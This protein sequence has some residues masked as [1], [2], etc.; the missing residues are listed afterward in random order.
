MKGRTMWTSPVALAAVTAQEPAASRDGRRPGRPPTATSTSRADET[1]RTRRH[2][3]ASGSPAARWRSSSRADLVRRGAH[4]DRAQRRLPART[5]RSREHPLL[6]AGGPL[7]QAGHPLSIR[8]DEHRSAGRR[9]ASY[10]LT[11]SRRGNRSLPTSKDVAALAGV[12][13]ST[14]SYVMSGKRSISPE[15][16]KRVED[17]IARLTYE[18]NAGARALRERRSNVIALVVRMSEEVDGADTVPYVDAVV[19]EAGKR[20]IEVVLVTGKAEPDRLTRL[21]KRSICDGMVLMDI[22]QHDDRIPVAASLGVPVVLIGTPRDSHGLQWVDFDHRRAAELLVTELAETGHRHAVFINE[23]FISEAPGVESEYHFHNEFRAGL[24]GAADT[25]GIDLELV[26]PRRPGWT[27]IS[28]VAE[29]LFRRSGDRLGLIARTPK[30]VG[31]AFQIA[32]VHR[33][34]PGRDFSLVGLCTDN[35]A[36]SYSVPVTNVSPQPR[37]T[38]RVA[39]SVLFDKLDGV[40]PDGE[41]RHLVGPRGLTRRASTTVFS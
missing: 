16:R 11:M 33:L 17:A 21:A 18:P 35:V 40:V 12:S 7:H 15:T 25:C 26:R 6:R 38:V 39:M 41:D 32:A 9:A 3:C 34:V 28:E 14:V 36:L 8:I 2:T 13:Q 24:A 20:D 19:E 10:A 37:D 27:G 4:P 31:W 5:R 30:V 23:D 22:R 29:R 1:P